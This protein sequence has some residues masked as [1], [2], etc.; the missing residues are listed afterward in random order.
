M[1][2]IDNKALLVR[3]KNPNRITDAIQKS[4]LV[5]QESEG[6]YKV[7]VHW[8]LPEAS[9]LATLVKNV[10]SPITKDYDWPGRFKPFAHQITTAEF[11]SLRRKAFCFSEQGTGKTASAIW[12]ADY[13]M[14]HGLVRR[15][16]VICP[17][18][19]MRSAWQ[20]DLFTFAVH[21]SCDVAHGT[22]EARLDVVR[23][24]AE[25]VIVNYD[26]VEIIADEVIRDGEFDLVIIDEASGYKNAQTRRWKTLKK[27][28]TPEVRVWMMTG[29]PAAQSPLDA[30]GLAKIVNPV[31]TPKFFGQ[32]RD[33]V[34]VKVGQ[35]RWIA[36]PKA[37][38][39]VHTI[40]QPAIRFL[41]KDC[42]DLP[43]VTHV[44]REA[45]LTPQQR[46]YYKL[47]KAKM[48]IEADGETITAVNAAVNMNKL[49]QISC[50]SVYTDDK[51][52]VDFDVSNRLNVIEEVINESSN[53]VLVFVPFTHAIELLHKHLTKAGITA[54]IINGDVSLNKRSTIFSKFQTTPD[55]KVL[56]IQPQAASHGLTLTA[57]DTIIWYAPV[58]SVETYLQANARID[59]PGQ[60]NPMTIVHITGSEVEHKIYNM[61]RNNID[62]HGKIVDLYRE[63]LE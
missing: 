59:R 48:L 17:L 25:F 6:V 49:L 1:D 19:I 50:G 15:A 60:V 51:Q 21:R 58:T 3:T 43:P 61:L 63:E 9:K 29:T 2:I 20:A 13:L 34:M 46:G 36:R 24:G 26:G 42:L 47:L 10:P 55:P 14:K 27:I 52:I 31:V 30:Y 32:Y 7:L 12:A 33:M 62:V 4:K 23:G 57:A 54:E 56:I 41:K 44:T 18:S 16:L 8:G 40:L 37:E 5:G 39:I 45:P 38:K 28:L 11:L 22:R 53:K 35:F